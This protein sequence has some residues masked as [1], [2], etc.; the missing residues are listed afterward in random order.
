ML[1]AERGL[2]LPCN[3]QKAMNIQT[4]SAMSEVQP[5]TTTTTSGKPRKKTSAACTSCRTRR[6]K[7]RSLPVPLPWFDLNS[8]LI[9]V[10]W[11]PENMSA[12][13]ANGTN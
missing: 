4:E 2:V 9:S 6:T 10:S 12:G 1:F 7:V 8:G 11:N 13:F 5:T 3:V